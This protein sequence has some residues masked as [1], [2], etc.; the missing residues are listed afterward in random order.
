MNIFAPGFLFRQIINN[1]IHY[2][3]P[4][5]PVGGYGIESPPLAASQLAIANWLLPS[6][7]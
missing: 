6:Y 3:L 4:D 5:P 1:I 2:C 7:L